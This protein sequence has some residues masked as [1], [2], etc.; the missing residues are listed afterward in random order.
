MGNSDLSGSILRLMRPTRP[1]TL[2]AFG[3][4]HVGWTMSCGTAKFVAD[5]LAGR[6][7]EI[8]GEGLLYG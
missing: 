4:G 7:T 2:F 8:D 3:H 1:S 6:P 5:C